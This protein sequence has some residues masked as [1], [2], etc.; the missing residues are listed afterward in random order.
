MNQPSPFDYC[1]C[2][3]QRRYHTAAGCKPP[4]RYFVRPDEPCPCT[5]FYGPYAADRF[6]RVLVC[7]GRH[8]A[9]RERVYRELDCLEAEHGIAIVLHGGA[10]GA[11][12][13]AEAWAISRCVP[14]R[15]YPAAWALHGDAAGPIRNA[16][17]LREGKPDLV[18]AFP[19]AKGTDDS[20]ADR[21]R[22]ADLVRRAEA[23][24]IEVLRIKED[25]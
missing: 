19:G 7:G 16:T 8:Y 10:P 2:T 15:W 6:L 5:G 14:T 11:D 1:G 24:G 18:V 9:D 25:E 13:L 3:H 17:M 4:Q 21:D 22:V 23:A 20:E 12:D